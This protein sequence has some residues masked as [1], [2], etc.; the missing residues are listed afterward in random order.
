MHNYRAP[1]TIPPSYIRVCVVVW[2][3]GEGQTD[4]QT[5]VANIHGMEIGLS[6]GNFVLDGDLAPLEKKSTPTTTQFLAHVYRGQMA[7]WMK[8]PLGM[9]VDIASGHIALDGV[10]A[11]A[12]GNPLFLVHVYCGHGRPSQ[13]LL[14]SCIDGCWQMDS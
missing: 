4:T 1:P 10:P 7:G 12:K 5:A 13:L 6:P 9:E 8:T 3:C 2:Q 11:P 14:S